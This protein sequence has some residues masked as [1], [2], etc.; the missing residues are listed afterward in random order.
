MKPKTLAAAVTA[1]IVMVFAVMAFA[2]TLLYGQSGA[3]KPFTV[4]GTNGTWMVTGYSLTTTPTNLSTLSASGSI[5]PPPRNQTVFLCGA[6]VNASAGTTA[7]VTIQDGIGNYFWNAIAPL[8]SG[9]PSSYNIP[10]GSG[11]S[12]PIGCRP[13]PSGL[14]VSAS[15]ASTIT[16]SAWGVY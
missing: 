12:A 11:A 4:P 8:S 7:S 16:F 1:F 13:F 14:V 3:S 9:N 2:A 10:V 15:S 5:A 6:D